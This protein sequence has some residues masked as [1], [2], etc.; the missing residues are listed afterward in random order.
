MIFDVFE[1]IPNHRNL[2]EK[3]VSKACILAYLR[4]FGTA[5]NILKTMSLKH[6]LKR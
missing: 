2:F 5:A 6:A 4:R 3:N 1:T